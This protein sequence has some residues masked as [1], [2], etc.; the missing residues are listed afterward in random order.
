MTITSTH[1]KTAFTLLVMLSPGC[2]TS[3]PSA[4]T[5]SEVKGFIAQSPSGGTLLKRDLTDF[6]C[7]SFKEA[8]W[9]RMSKPVAKVIWHQYLGLRISFYDK[10]SPNGVRDEF[11]TSG[12]SDPSDLGNLTA[13]WS[14]KGSSNKHAH[15]ISSKRYQDC[16]SFLASVKRVN[17]AMRTSSY[18][19]AGIRVIAM[20]IA[21]VPVLGGRPCAREAQAGSEAWLAL[22]QGHSNTDSCDRCTEVIPG[23]KWS[24]SSVELTDDAFTDAETRDLK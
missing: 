2:K 24:K 9:Y 6:D 3:S 14:L 22:D 18:Q 7:K 5:D 13:W 16:S 10:S 23:A 19:N 8:H 15:M 11:E 17:D 12:L 4:K 20:V 21:P 1:L